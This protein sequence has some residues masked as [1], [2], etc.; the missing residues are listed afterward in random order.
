MGHLSRIAGPARADNRK[1]RSLLS[2]SR[3]AGYSA[4]TRRSVPS[5]PTTP[6]V[7]MRLFLSAGEPSGDLHGAN[8][9]RAL[10]QLR[11]DVEILGF[12]GERLAAAGCRLVYPLCNLAVVGILPVLRSV[13]TFARIL[14]LARETFRQSRPDAVVLIDYPGFHWW[15]AGAARREGI[16]VSYFV[17]PQLWAWAGW[18]VRK[19]RRLTDQVL[20]SLPFEETWFRQR[21]VAARYIG[22]PY[23]DELHRQR[24]DPDFVTSQRGRPGSVVGILPGS[25]HSELSRNLPSLLRAA[26][27]IH[28]RRPDTRFLVACLHARHAQEVR[29]HF[30]AAGVPAEVHHGRTPEVIHLAHSCL[31]VSGSVSLELLFRGKPAA[32]VYNVP[33]AAVAVS[34]LLL[35]C[36]YIT[37]VNL[38][39]DRLLFPE[40]VTSGNAGEQL[41]S[42]V[43]RWLEDRNAYE[44]LCGELG[45]LRR[46]VAE[47]GA[48]DRAAAAVLEL[49]GTA[50]RRA[51]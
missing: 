25:R 32:I 43:L 42:H 4:A 27:C 18:R 45:A 50:R 46:R 8:L 22:H 37:L 15:L 19:M 26:Q 10:K 39:A 7:L 49:A 38:L 6:G 1:E 9:A 29:P 51:A 3:P 20:C 12:G 11:P 35:R 31:A 24:L 48:C 36:K 17:P 16:P 47:P 33:A 28:A 5:W 34:K 2:R 21:G 13:P 23:F 41:A 30:A 14:G 44:E 40:H